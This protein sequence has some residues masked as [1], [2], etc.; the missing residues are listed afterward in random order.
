MYECLLYILASFCATKKY[1]NIVLL[2]KFRNFTSYKLLIFFNIYF[3]SDENKLNTLF[4]VFSYLRN[5]VIL[6]ALIRFCIKDIKRD[7][8][9]L[10][11]FIIGTGN[12]SKS[13]LSS[14]I[15][16]LQLDK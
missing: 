5:P 15:P 11:I 4:A 14:G 13:L 6:Y 10:S 7:N 9:P 1:F 3:I 12:G 2:L 16:Y 8:N